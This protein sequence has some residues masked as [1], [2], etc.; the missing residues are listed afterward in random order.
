MRSCKRRSYIS[1]PPGLRV[2]VNGGRKTGS[3]APTGRLGAGAFAVDCNWTNSCAPP[4]RS[5]APEL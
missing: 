2:Y 4:G 3:A 1:E 5:G